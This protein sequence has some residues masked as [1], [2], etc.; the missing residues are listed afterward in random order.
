MM[1]KRFTWIIAAVVVSASAWAQ[2]SLVSHVPTAPVFNQ[3]SGVTQRRPVTVRENEGP[4]VWVKV[5]PSFTYNR[6]WVYWTLDGTEPQGSNGNAGTGSTIVQASIDRVS[7]VRPASI[8]F[9]YNQSNGFGGNDDWWKLTLPQVGSSRAYGVTIRYK[10]SAQQD[11]GTE[12]FA[13]GGASY[14]YTNKLAWPGAGAGQPNG[15]AGYPPV[16]F[17]K[18]EAIFGNTYAAGMID[19]NGT[20]YDFHFPTT[21][22]VQG[23]GTKNEGYV[24]G[25]DTFPPLLP[26]AWRGQ[27]HVNQAM[28]GI[29]TL[30]DNQ[31]HWL[32]NPA[33]SNSFTGVSQAY[34]PTSNSIITTQSLT[35]GGNNIAVRQD[36]FSPIGI[37][38]PNDRGGSP[39]RH[40]YLKRVTLTNNTGSA[41]D[42]NVYWY[43][44]HALNG[45]DSYDGAFADST[46]G[47]MVAFDTGGRTVTGTN[48]TNSPPAFVPPTITGG[49]PNEYNPTTFAGYAKNISLYLVSAMRLNNPDGSLATRVTDYWSESSGDTDRG[50]IGL[51]ATL[52]PGQPVTLDVM[53]VG[54][55]DR[56]A[57]ATGTY[58]FK[59][60]TVVDWFYAN[61]MGAVLAAT[62]TYWS[63]WLNAGV[64]VD[65]PDN[66]YDA[67]MRRGLL[68]T[69]LHQSAET[70]AIIAGF[71]NG[72]YPFAWPRDAMWAAVT[73]IRAGH[74]P[75]AENSLRWMRDICYRDVEPSF[76][77]NPISGQPVR[78]FWKQKYSTDGFT[79]WGAPQIDGTAV[80]PWAL[81][82]YYDTTGDSTLLNAHYAS[83]WDAVQAMTRDSLD[84][85]LRFEEGVNL[86][87]TNN[88]WEDQYDVFVFSN[89]NVVRGL[90]DAAAIATILGRPS[91]AANFN[92]LANTIKGG[93]DAR[94]DWNGENTD[95][96]QL[97]IVYPFQVYSPVETRAVRIID[98]I[99]GVAND[100]F[101]NN[102][103]LVRF[104]GFPNDQYGWTG[105]IDRYWGDGYWGGG[106][107]WGA[108]PWY[109]TTMWYGAYY[110]MRQDYTPNKSDIDNHKS[111]M[112]LLVNAL[113]PVGFGAEQVAPKYVNNS[114]PGSLL[115]PGQNDFVLQTAWPNAWESMSFFVDAIMMFLDYTPDSANNLIKVSPKL[116][117]AWPTMT[118]NGL[119]LNRTPQGQAHRV[120]LTVAENL[121]G[122]TVTGT[123]TN[124]TGLPL[125][126]QITLRVPV[127]SPVCRV[128]VNGSPVGG[129]AFDAATGRVTVTTALS[130]GVNAQTVVRVW[131]RLPADIDANGTVGAND[132]SLLLAA[133]G[134]TP[135]SP[136][137]NPAADIDSNG[138]VGAND[139]SILLASYGQACP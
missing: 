128:T 117:S 41:Q 24:D 112:D 87:F 29:R 78:G 79:I 60:E 124:T 35:G 20:V 45:G 105:M 130:T 14:T 5:G 88:L 50:W 100:T 99:N 97:G 102:R 109:L 120:N 106:Q 101:G 58:A 96:S 80:Y 65:F 127:P 69:A 82:W 57:G 26:A 73:L 4:D 33:G 8:F 61:D 13:N 125:N 75:E 74:L 25:P 53:M 113:G 94:L 56:F 47:A 103:P 54:V 23:V 93:L 115:Y 49:T 22:G 92:G 12:V 68:A 7:P 86:M 83:V 2:P 71:H 114:L 95:A 107:P 72:A 55:D 76:G 31:T 118:W 135:A 28:L 108:G 3:P 85:R 44:D 77:T 46:R 32:S 132:L 119:R 84:S 139:L 43:L 16:S 38:F 63:N 6:V 37:A 137:W 52:P 91:D 11:G 90:R 18:E 42:V 110:A 70:G 66:R 126:A 121:P 17:W 10:V 64:T 131:G 122:K 39:Q 40:I 129:F 34:N 36:D 134:S 123:F 1:L 133:F 98:R 104:A 51:R 136:N 89:A 67:L 21:G 27:M 9:Q 138:A 48:F 15:Q 30:G 81:K 59:G 111:R 19:Q 62:D 116:P